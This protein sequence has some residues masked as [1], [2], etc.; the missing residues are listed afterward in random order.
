MRANDFPANE[1]GYKSRYSF[2]RRIAPRFSTKSDRI[3]RL[4]EGLIKSDETDSSIRV[5]TH[6]NTTRIIAMQRIRSGLP[7]VFALVE[8]ESYYNSAD[9]FNYII[10]RSDFLIKLPV[11]HRPEKH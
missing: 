10:A 5:E 4:G 8:I 11:S 6:R 1:V 3:G 2:G 9:T 7:S